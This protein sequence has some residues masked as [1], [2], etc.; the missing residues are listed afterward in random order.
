MPA[1]QEPQGRRG[2]GLRILK[3]RVDAGLAG[4][5]SPSPFSDRELIRR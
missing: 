4:G 2:N 3:A 1:R 5:V